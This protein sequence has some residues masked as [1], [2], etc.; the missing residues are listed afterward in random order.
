MSPYEDAGSQ[1]VNAAEVQIFT[2][3]TDVGKQLKDE[4]HDSNQEMLKFPEMFMRFV[5]WKAG[6]K[7]LTV[8]L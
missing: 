8:Q 7:P 5:F 3:I 1:K 4:S 6:L 2:K